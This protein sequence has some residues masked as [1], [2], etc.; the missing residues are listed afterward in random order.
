MWDKRSS[1]TVGAD[2]VLS[3]DTLTR[4]SNGGYPKVRNHRE[5]PYYGLLLVESA[6]LT[7]PPVPYGNCV[8][9]QFHIE[10]PWGQHLFSIVS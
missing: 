10:R 2:L 5:G 4:D 3:C 6:L 8:A 1:L 7:N 9:D